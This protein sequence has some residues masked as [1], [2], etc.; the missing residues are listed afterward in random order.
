M[1]PVAQWQ[2]AALWQQIRGFDPR[3]APHQ[4]HLFKA[5]VFCYS[6]FMTDLTAYNKVLK[7]ALATEKNNQELINYIESHRNEWKGPILVNVNLIQR[8]VGPE[9]YMLNYES[10]KDFGLKVETIKNQL[11]NHPKDR[12][13]IVCEKLKDS[14]LILDGNHTF[15]A[16]KQLG[17]DEIKVIYAEDSILHKLAVH[18]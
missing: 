4:K 7:I 9:Q 10:H 3:R 5:G 1:V 18:N 2:S 14:Y 6:I 17:K 11:Q 8:T 13:N 16:V 15:E 12:I